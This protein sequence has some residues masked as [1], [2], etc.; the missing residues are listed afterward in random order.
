MRMSFRTNFLKT[1]LKCALSRL[2]FCFDFFDDLLFERLL[3]SFDDLFLSFDDELFFFFEDEEDFFCA[4]PAAFR[5]LLLFFNFEL[6][7]SFLESL[8]RSVLVPEVTAVS[9]D[10]SCSLS[11]NISNVCAST[12]RHFSLA[13][14]SCRFICFSRPAA[15]TS[16][17]AQSRLVSRSSA[18]KS[19]SLSPSLP[20]LLC[21]ASSCRNRLTFE[22]RLATTMSFSSNMRWAVSMSPILFRLVFRVPSGFELIAVST[23]S[24]VIS[25][26]TETLSVSGDSPVSFVLLISIGPSMAPSPSSHSSKISPTL[27]RLRLLSNAV[28]KISSSLS[29][30]P[31]LSAP[32]SSATE[33]IASESSES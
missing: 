1:A 17:S 21:P 6:C 20:S 31:T 19:L 9:L 5:L 28:S 7:F 16:F 32:P 13:S 29:S 2:S 24:P 10:P 15:I 26:P 27:G 4:S 33:Y 14:Y 30:V 8:L 25:D 11:L 22:T 12:M 3:L 23:V 18:A